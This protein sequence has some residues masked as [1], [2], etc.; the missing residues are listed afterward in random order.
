MAK[1]DYYEVLGVERGASDAELKKAFRGLARELHPDVNDHDPAAEEKFKEAAEAYEVLSDP[2]RRRTYDAFGHEGLLRSGGWTPGET[3]SSFQDI[4]EALF[5]GDPFG[6]GFGFGRGGPAAGGDVAATLEIELTDVLEGTKREVSFE[7]VGLCEHCHGNGAEPGTPIRTCDRCEGTG[8]LRQVSR[9]V[10]GQVVRTMPCDRC[11]GDGRI[12]ETPCEHCAGRG[13]TAEARTWEVDIPPGI[14]D[15][16]RVRITGAGHAGEA[17]A[18]QGD[19][20]V[21]V[22]VAPDERF[23]RQGTELVSRVQMPVTTAMLGG[24]VAVPTLEGEERVEVPVGAQHGDVTVL[25]GNGLPPLQGGPRGDQHVVFELVVPERL[26]GAQ[27]EAAERLAESFEK[28][29]SR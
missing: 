29:T 1:R 16:Q 13:R 24:E 15:G 10:F 19:L 26:T 5:G 4:F 14:E 21:E 7:A 28:Q 18:R 9:S 6:G 2:E 12:A 11:G 22:R 17:G 23:A 8:Q 3:F 27:R 25:N 20:Y